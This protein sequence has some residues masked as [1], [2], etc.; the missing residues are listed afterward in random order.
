MASSKS[1]DAQ[2]AVF[3][4]AWGNR[5]YE[6]LGPD[7][8]AVQVAFVM[9]CKKSYRQIPTYEPDDARPNGQADGIYLQ[10]AC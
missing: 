3:L 10:Q 2:P 7:H 5:G 1:L 8:F 6:S 9:H 4:N